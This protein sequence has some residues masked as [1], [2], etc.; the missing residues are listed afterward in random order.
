MEPGTRTAISGTMN[1][2]I[3]LLSAAGLVAAFAIGTHSVPEAVAQTTKAPEAPWA[4]S[5]SCR[6][7]PGANFGRA[8]I[9]LPANTRVNI[10]FLTAHAEVPNGQRAVLKFTSTPPRSSTVTD[11]FALTP[12]LSMP[13]N[14]WGGAY[15][16]SQ[17][18][19]TLVTSERVDIAVASTGTFTA[20]CFRAQTAGVGYVAFTLHGT[21]APL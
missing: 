21:S 15:P 5:A 8:S 4:A 19:D 6:F 17:T 14:P 11:S 2:S 7:E 16:S 10:T 1:K 13:N 3:L 9:P 20:G 12:Q 18:M